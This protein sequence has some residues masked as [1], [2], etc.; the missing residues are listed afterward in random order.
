[1][2]S[3]EGLNLEKVNSF[4][5]E[6]PA[7][8]QSTLD[9]VPGTKA[10]SGENSSQKSCNM[11]LE[12]TDCCGEKV[13]HHSQ[14]S[15]DFMSEVTDDFERDSPNSP[16]STS[17]WDNHEE[18]SSEVDDFNSSDSKYKMA[19]SD[20]IHSDRSPLHVADNFKA[21]NLDTHQHIDH[22]NRDSRVSQ[23]SSKSDS[24][25]QYSVSKEQAKK[26]M[27]DDKGIDKFAKIADE[28]A[29]HVSE[30]YNGDLKISIRYEKFPSLP[31]VTV[32]CLPCCKTFQLSHASDR[33]FYIKDLLDGSHPHFKTCSK[34]TTDDQNLRCHQSRLSKFF[35]NESGSTPKDVQLQQVKR[36]SNE[37]S[38]IGFGAKS[39]INCFN[40]NQS[41]LFVA[42]E[43]FAW[44][45]SC[46]K[47]T[48]NPEKV[49]VSCIKIEQTQ[50]SAMKKT[51][52]KLVSCYPLEAREALRK[53]SEKSK[54]TSRKAKY[55][56]KH[57]INL[58]S[59]LV[60]AKNQTLSEYLHSLANKV[61]S[62]TNN[63]TEVTD[64][65]QSN[66]QQNALAVLKFGY[67]HSKVL[68]ALSVLVY[69][70]SQACSR[71][72]NSCPPFVFSS[73]SACKKIR[74]PEGTILMKHPGMQQAKKMIAEHFKT[75]GWVRDNKIGP[76]QMVHDSTRVR[77]LV[78]ADTNSMTLIGFKARNNAQGMWEF[79]IP[80][81]SLS[82]INVAFV[83]NKKASYVLLGLYTALGPGVPPVTACIIPHDNK[84]SLDD[85]KE[86]LKVM[87]LYW[88]TK[89]LP[90][91]QIGSDFESKNLNYLEDLAIS[92]SG[93][94]DDDILVSLQD[95]VVKPTTGEHGWPL[96]IN[97]DAKHGLK[98]AR[99]QILYVDKVIPAL[100]GAGLLQYFEDARC[101]LKSGLTKH[102]VDPDDRQDVEEAMA[103]L[104]EQ[105]RRVIFKMSR[106][107]PL[108][109]YSFL[110]QLMYDIYYSL[111]PSLTI[112]RRISLAGVIE[113]T[114]L[115][116]RTWICDNPLYSLSR[117]FVSAQFVKFLVLQSQSY[118]TQVLIHK[119]YF[120]EFPFCT[121]FDGSDH[122]EHHFQKLAEKFG[123]YSTK[124]MCD[125]S[126]VISGEQKLLS[127]LPICLDGKHQEQKES[128]LPSLPQGCKLPD[129]E[130][131]MKL[132]KTGRKFDNVLL[133][134]LGMQEL[135]ISRNHWE[136]PLMPKWKSL[137]TRKGSSVCNDTE[138][139]EEEEEDDWEC[140]ND[141]SDEEI[142]DSFVQ[143][144]D[145]IAKEA[146]MVDKGDLAVAT[147]EC[148]DD[149]KEERSADDYCS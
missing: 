109:V 14:S 45:K 106:N 114:I 71:I 67:R 129:E 105:A 92:M 102:S 8:S 12:D 22:E 9:F 63:I 135:L 44:S 52:F 113:R 68:Q 96:N 145:C 126:C 75:Y 34:K 37:F 28:I 97:G 50:T 120:R 74:K 78:K 123:N 38:C 27:N 15:W 60:Q 81:K 111:H 125:E 48:R 20:S 112:E 89:N 86:W 103:F 100:A 104:S 59:L 69:N 76:L 33:Y 53:V 124:E 131:A 49:C 80:Y 11:H 32:T 25:V 19:Y 30:I 133:E 146:E 137:K 127:D 144:L 36:L 108:A 43:T 24:N 56:Q 110:S 147:D 116:W 16:T 3:S 23:C 7:H 101:D 31:R 51:K 149:G 117:N 17:C 35:M 138:D 134:W 132:F 91:A 122:C 2:W 143:E 77:E 65:L 61:Q 94:V 128:C 40:A 140:E 26:L 29:V 4:G 72:L 1:M 88:K 121:A 115:G 148:E 139:D 5:N 46:E 87:E 18:S 64:Y 82:D 58:K 79:S 83:D 41:L 119:K 39:G 141:E 62:S 54:S 118:L 90:I 136:H 84:F 42:N 21:S 95:W 10:C 47:T 98:L 142:R 85:L 73:P 57:S 130:M 93:Q 70:R 99:A 13:Y 107:L 55:F 6:T 66:I